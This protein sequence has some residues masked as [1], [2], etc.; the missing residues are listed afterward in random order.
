MS[1]AE[2]QKVLIPTE[3]DLSSS[4]STV[5]QSRVIQPDTENLGQV[6]PTKGFLHFLQATPS[7]GADI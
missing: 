6:G 5:I 2:T 4:R 7:F 3:R 1:P